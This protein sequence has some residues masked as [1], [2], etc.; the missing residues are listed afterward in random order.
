MMDKLERI[1]NVAA[2][3][4]TFF[5]YM[6]LAKTIWPANLSRSGDVISSWPAVLAVA[7]IVVSVLTIL[8]QVSQYR[9]IHRAPQAAPSAPSLPDPKLA[10]F[11][12]LIPLLQHEYVEREL[13]PRG[14]SL[15][16]DWLTKAVG[17]LAMRLRREELDRAD[18]E[19]KLDAQRRI[20]EMRGDSNHPFNQGNHPEHQEALDEMS[21]LYRILC[22]ETKDKN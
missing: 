18:R 2:I 11:E 6:A 14:E 9:S 8:A 16:A 17:R 12:E 5:G 20:S 1:G 13:A 7:L 3:P 19:M 21:S 22:P 10:P 15:P 4:L